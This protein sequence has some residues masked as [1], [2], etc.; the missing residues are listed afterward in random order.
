MIIVSGD[1][2]QGLL[3]M[4]DAIETVQTAMIA[5]SAGRATMPLR[6]IMEIDGTNRLGIMPGALRDPD[7]Y[8]VKLISL[9]P[10]NPAK[11]LSSHIGQMV[12]FDNDT[13]A[14]TACLDADALTAIRT[15]AASAAATRVLARQDA[16]VLA[17]IGTGE[18]AMRHIEAMTCVRDIFEVR[19]A[20]RTRDRAVAF[21]KR[22]GPKFPDLTFVAAQD[23][24]KAVQGA[25]I[26]CTVTS[27]VT[28]VLHGDWIAPGVHVNAVGAS[29]PNMQEIDH[30]LLMKS[31]LFVDYRASALAQAREIIDALASGDMDKAHIRG[32]IG[33]LYAGEIAGR[34][35]DD[36]VTLYRSLG[37]AAQDLACARRVL[38]IRRLN[39]G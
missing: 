29:I 8:G 19:V 31:A 37:V 3:A 18:Q 5:V 39:H 12:I 21:I 23:A 28:P 9:F 24:R 22:V 27:S 35:D 33:Q 14:V 20:G 32:E 10:G 15:A 2:I 17:V 25:D 38:E 7:V 4:N 16:Q 11:G 26:V 13:G 1:E 30:G 36:E 6:S 34:R